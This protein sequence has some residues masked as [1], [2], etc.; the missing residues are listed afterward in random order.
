MSPSVTLAVAMTTTVVARQHSLS[1]SPIEP[2]LLRNIGLFSQLSVE[3][4]DGVRLSGIGGGVSLVTVA[5]ETGFIESYMLSW[6]L[7][8]WRWAWLLNDI[9]INRRSSR[10]AV[11]DL[12]RLRGR[13]LFG[14]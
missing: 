11:V 1:S 12:F 7:C 6:E 4:S 3:T 9:R 5:T 2:R 13:G 14:Q 10:Q 8:G